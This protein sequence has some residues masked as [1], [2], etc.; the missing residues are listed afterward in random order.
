MNEAIADAE[1]VGSSFSEDG[2]LAA[3]ALTRAAIADIAAAIRPG[4]V[5]EDAVELAKG[6]LAAKGLRPTWHPVRVRFG[7]NTT[8][9]MKQA[10]APGV[11]LGESDIFF[12]D[13]APRFEA[14]E[15]DGGA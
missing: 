1:R 8:R 7:S 3:R 10:S 12:V 13:I 5:E 2:M 4:M 6:V 15:G 9:A 11:V 14:W